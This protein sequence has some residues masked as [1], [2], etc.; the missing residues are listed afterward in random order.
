MLVDNNV[1]RGENY[2]S[3]LLNNWILIIPIKFLRLIF[4]CLNFGGYSVVMDFVDCCSD[5]LEQIIFSKKIKIN[6][7][8]F[9]NIIIWQCYLL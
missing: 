7:T 4:I 2:V 9:V 3:F 5:N 1:N 8:K 6:V